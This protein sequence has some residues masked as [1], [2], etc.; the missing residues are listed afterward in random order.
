RN[1]GPPPRVTLVDADDAWLA[2]PRVQPGADWRRHPVTV[3][4]RSVGWLISPPPVPLAISDEIDQRFQARQLR[5]TWVIVGL[6]V[7]LAALVSLLLARLL[8]VPVRR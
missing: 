5:A 3:A 4:G 7:L 1:G 8:L 2:G 6:S